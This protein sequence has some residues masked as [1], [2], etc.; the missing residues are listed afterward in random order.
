MSI[1]ERCVAVLDALAEAPNGLTQA[2]LGSE[3]QL[4]KPTVSRLVQTMCELDLLRRD[5]LRKIYVLGPA[6][7]RWGMAAVNGLELRAVAHPHLEVLRETT[8]ET[9]HLAVLDASSVVYLDRLESPH[10]IRMASRL[11][12]TM[13]AHSTA[14]GKCLMAFLPADQQQTIVAGPLAARTSRTITEPPVL[15]RELDRVRDQGFAVE[16]GENEEGVGCAAAPLFDHVG[17]VVAAISVSSPEFRLAAPD[18]HARAVVTTANAIS[19]ILGY[20]AAAGASSRT[21]TSSPS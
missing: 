2:Q 3:L 9:V 11:G 13:P 8:G 6:I 17:Q 7:I 4:A 21:S 5:E 18:Q 19:A 12:S 10:A 20:R 14:M 15:Q 16:S 1:M